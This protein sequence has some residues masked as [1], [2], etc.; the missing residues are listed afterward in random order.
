MR[1]CAAL[2]VLAASLIVQS[3]LGQIQDSPGA[4]TNTSVQTAPAVET[5]RPSAPQQKLLLLSEEPPLLLLDDSAETNAPAG[6]ADNS[7]CQVCH[8]NFMQEQLSLVHSRT[9]IGCANCHGPSDAHIADESWASGGNGTAP[10]VMFPL[11]KINTACME[12]HKVAT[13]IASKNHK[14][15]DV[16]L[17]AY[18]LKVCTECHGKHR[19]VTRKCKWK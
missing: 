1:F 12:C 19:M 10:D 15:E 6:G 18:N 14:P 7:R 4:V 3:S 8:V 11:S 9:N 2:A 13:V 17:I 5:N 16:W